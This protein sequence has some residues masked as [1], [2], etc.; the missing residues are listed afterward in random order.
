M[1]LHSI[2]FAVFVLW[3]VAYVAKLTAMPENDVLDVVTLTGAAFV[4]GL[5]CRGIFF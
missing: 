4:C 2:I 5:L 1:M 3:V